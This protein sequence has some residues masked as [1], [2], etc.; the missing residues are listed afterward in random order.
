M[1]RRDQGPERIGDRGDRGRSRPRV[2]DPSDLDDP[3]PPGGLTLGAAI[4]R[5]IHSNRDLS[6]K[7]H[8]IPQAQADILTAGLRS[9]PIIFW[10]AGGTPYGRW[11]N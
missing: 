11:S 2:P 9:N 6:T 8:E 3:G 7:Y 4:D 1:A 5:L 10:S